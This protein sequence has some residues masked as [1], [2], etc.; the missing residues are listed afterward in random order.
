MNVKPTLCLASLATLLL[1]CSGGGGGGNGGNGDLS[2]PDLTSAPLDMTHLPDMSCNGVGSGAAGTTCTKASDCGGCKPACSTTLGGGLNLS[3]PE[4][5]CSGPCKRDSDCGEGGFCETTTL[6]YCL[7]TCVNKGDC[8]TA[9]SANANNVCVPANQ[10]T[11]VC[12]PLAH[13]CNPTRL[14]D[15]NN[16]GACFRLQ[17]AIDDVGNCLSPCD[18]GGSC[19]ADAAGNAQSC[20]FL[21]LTIDANKKATGDKYAGMGCFIDDSGNAADA[22]GGG[23]PNTACSFLNSCASGYECDFYGG[24]LCK[25]LCRNGVDNNCPGG[26]TCQNAFQLTTFAQNDVGLCL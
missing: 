13:D 17:G 22:P 12:L 1:A 26:T 11:N 19:P 25:A 15:C 23:R 5:Y 10:T 16:T 9:A 3:V 2:M 18:I 14:T 6:H 4:G 7:G 8:G 24:K 20:Y 21:N